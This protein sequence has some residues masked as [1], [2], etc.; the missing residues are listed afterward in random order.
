MFLA[1]ADQDTPSVYAL[2][3]SP[4]SLYSLMAHFAIILG[5][6]IDPETAPAIDIRHVNLETGEN[7]SEPYLTEISKKGQ[8]GLTLRNISSNGM[9]IENQ[10][11]KTQNR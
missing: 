5:Q 6:R 8:V 10:K 1:M 2:H 9:G 3:T 4:F 7:L 11:P